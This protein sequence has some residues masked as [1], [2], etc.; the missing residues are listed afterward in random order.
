MKNEN[1]ITLVA[2]AITIVVMII[3][4]FISV[5]TGKDAYSEMQLQ[6]FEAKMKVIQEKVNLEIENYKKWEK[7]GESGINI[8]DYVTYLYQKNK[9]FFLPL[10]L[11]HL[12]KIND[13]HLIRTIFY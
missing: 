6:A 12:N 1:G 11:D 10:E 13:H 5:N 9:Q 7:Y 3:I 2:L 4:I 8:N